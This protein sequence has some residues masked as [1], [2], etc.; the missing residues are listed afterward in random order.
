MDFIENL[1]SN[2]ILLMALGAVVVV[3]G[4]IAFVLLTG[5][6]DEELHP[7]TVQ[8]AEAITNNKSEDALVLLMENADSLDRQGLD[9][10]EELKS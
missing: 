10:L 4:I 3:G 6:D 8:A 7:I 9:L 2:K 1:K 5:G